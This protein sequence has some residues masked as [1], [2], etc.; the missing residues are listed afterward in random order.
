MDEYS[1]DIPLLPLVGNTKASDVPSPEEYTY[2]KDRKNRCFYIDY[3]I[4]DDF[5]LIELSKIIV[6]MNMEEMN[7]PEEELKPIYLWLFTYGGSLDQAQ[8]FCDLVESSRIP[9][10][11][12]C[13]GAAMSAGFL[14]FLAG[15]KRY[16]FPHSRMLVH[17]GSGAFQGTA[18]QIEEAQK[19]YKKQINEMKEYILART[20]IPER[21]F[22]KNRSKDW[23]LTAADLEEYKIVDKI[24]TNIS[25]IF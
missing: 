16:A 5:M 10:I 15:K 12:I 23:Y 4:D 22:S 6:Q 3:I 21:I 1:F 7:I 19:D 8:Y 24:I 17:S 18:E 25:E 2:W 11:T 9:I 13:M 20:S 14:I